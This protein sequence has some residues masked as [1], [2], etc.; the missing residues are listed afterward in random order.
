MDQ[1]KIRQKGNNQIRHIVQGLRVS[2]PSS[3]LQQST[4]FEAPDDED[5]Y[6]RRSITVL[7]C[8]ASTSRRQC[9][10]GNVQGGL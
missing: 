10:G 9:P 7:I 2:I 5:L 8:S 6:L 3:R 1:S 4:T